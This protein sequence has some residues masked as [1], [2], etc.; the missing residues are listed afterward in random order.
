[1][2]AERLVGMIREL[3]AMGLRTDELQMPAE[4]DVFIG[5]LLAKGTGE[6]FLPR[7]SDA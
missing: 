5:D 1:M 6:V 4:V 7:P 2:Q 3:R